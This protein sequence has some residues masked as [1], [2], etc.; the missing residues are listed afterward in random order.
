MPIK[1]NAKVTSQSFVEGIFLYNVDKQINKM[2]NKNSKI[3]CLLIKFTLSV[4]YLFYLLFKTT[5][6]Y[7]FAIGV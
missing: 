1:E 5:K 6:C 4:L 2:R 7:T 3:V